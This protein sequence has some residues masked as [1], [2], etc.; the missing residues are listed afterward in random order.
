MAKIDLWDDGRSGPAGCVA[1]NIALGSLPGSDRPIRKL[2]GTLFETRRQFLIGRACSTD[3]YLAEPVLHWANASW[4]QHTDMAREAGSAGKE[5]AYLFITATR[6]PPSVQTWLV[7]ATVVEKA[8]EARQ[9]DRRG[10]M[11]AI[12]IVSAGNRHLLGGSDITGFHQ[13]LG[14]SNAETTRLRQAYLARQ[15][16]RPQPASDRPP[17]AGRV[18]AA[19]P[20]SAGAAY[21]I[22]V[23]RSR[24]VRLQL[25]GPLLLSDVNRVKQWLDL[26]ADVLTEGWD[27][28]EEARQTQWL[29]EQVQTGLDELSRG[30]GV[31]GEK[32]FA[33]ILSRS[34][35]QAGA[36]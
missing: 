4:D 5:L 21:D 10:Q 34:H 22:P 18:F 9:K 35:A 17:K 36:R 28:T 8:F 1:G 30:E 24:S 26:A 23:S 11:C 3:S 14:L 29:Q 6:E 13:A 32:A 25:P 27:E 19:V 33:R 31:D 12:H 15:P 20:S 2:K 7:P 16:Q